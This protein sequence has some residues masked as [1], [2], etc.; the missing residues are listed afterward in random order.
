MK[1]A[2]STLE[3]NSV[4]KAI[5]Y[6]GHEMS[7]LCGWEDDPRLDSNR[8]VTCIYSKWEELINSDDS[9]IDDNKT[10]MAQIVKEIEKNVSK[11]SEKLKMTIF[12]KE[13][14]SFIWHLTN[15]SKDR[16][17]IVSRYLKYAKNYNDVLMMPMAS[18]LV[19]KCN[20]DLVFNQVD[21]ASYS[22]KFEKIPTVYGK[23]Y[24]LTV[25]S[26]EALAKCK[27]ND[28]GLIHILIGAAFRVNPCGFMP[29]FCPHIHHGGNLFIRF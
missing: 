1:S 24:N 3:C 22:D 29:P 12:D 14:D 16:R 25:L 5:L 26:G 17:F 21:D 27:P 13:K 18:S 20:Y 6:C 7:W 23:G 11:F 4:V 2:C 19:D 8:C 15:H 10:L 9:S 28:K